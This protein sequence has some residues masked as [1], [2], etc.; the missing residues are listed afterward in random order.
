MSVVL[1]AP[2][3]VS[4][5][6][7]SC[8]PRPWLLVLLGLAVVAGVVA[9]IIAATGSDDSDDFRL[10][11]TKEVAAANA[12][13]QRLQTPADATRD[14]YGNAC[15]L[16][17]VTYCLTSAQL[18][19]EQLFDDMLNEVRSH[20]ASVKT[21]ECAAPGKEPALGNIVGRCMA[22]VHYQGTQLLVGADDKAVLSD[23]KVP[24]WLVVVPPQTGEVDITSP[25]PPLGTWDSLHLVPAGWKARA[26]CTLGAGKA[27]SGYRV[28]LTRPGTASSVIDTLRRT[29]IASGYAVFGDD[30]SPATKADA[31]SCLLNAHRFRT[32]GGKNPVLLIVSARQVSQSS[33]TVRMIVAEQLRPTTTPSITLPSSPP[34]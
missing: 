20:G 16:Q 29:V 25:E 17:Y 2:P 28:T 6:P 34:S 13:V 14:L 27:C 24:T 21:H 26:I 11:T 19:P 9:I 15:G 3:G 18:T 8:W 33:T 22:E 32:V 31:A 7:K 12:L 5:P 1:E 4:P 30:C 23:S 10:P